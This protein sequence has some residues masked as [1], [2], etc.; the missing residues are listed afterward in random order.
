MF[1]KE[2]DKKIEYIPIKKVL[3]N[4]YQPRKDFTDRSIKRLSDSIKACGIIQPVNVR[5]RDDGKY[6][7]VSGERRV[8]AAKEVGLKYIPAIVSRLTDEESA[9]AAL[10]E[11]LQ[12]ENLSFFEEAEGYY[13][14]LTEHGFTQ[15]ELAKKIGRSQGTIANKI[16]L[17]KLFPRTKELVKKHNLSE[18]H[19]RALL[20]ISDE[21]Y[22]VRTAEAIC[23]KEYSVK[24]AERVVRA[25]LERLT[26]A[27]SFAFS[28]SPALEEFYGVSEYS[29]GTKNAKNIKIFINT[30]KE[31][32]RLLKLSGVDA[33]AA[34]FDRGDYFEFVVR[35]PKES[36]KLSGT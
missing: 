12:R 11:N 16:R 33:K 25:T 35:I 6:E 1:G 5:I 32:I 7:L 31:T 14:L 9:V 23:E 21:K 34:Q 30:I 28:E 10:V 15:S 36:N 18:R 17:L 26:N 4:P 29:T 3:A 27:K 13:A 8:R 20:R 22:Q 24:K 2:D 19:A